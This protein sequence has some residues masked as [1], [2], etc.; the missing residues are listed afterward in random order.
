MIDQRFK[1][2]KFKRLTHDKII[3]DPIASITRNS[4]ILEAN[5]NE[6]LTEILR[7]KRHLSRES[8]VNHF[9]L[10]FLAMPKHNRV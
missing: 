8:S 4:N 6:A 7:K 9:D 10:E 5:T 3:S 2:G 1:E